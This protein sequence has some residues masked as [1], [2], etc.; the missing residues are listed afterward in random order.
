MSSY[1][2]SSLL[3][4]AVIALFQVEE[5]LKRPET[6]ENIMAATPGLESDPDAMG[7][8]S[9]ITYTQSLNNSCSKVN[10]DNLIKFKL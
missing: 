7:Q 2:A 4:I 3:V 6:L 10:S 1:Q 8:F 9:I 5:M